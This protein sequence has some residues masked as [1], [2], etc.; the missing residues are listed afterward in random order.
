ML[1]GVSIALVAGLLVYE[2]FDGW[3]GSVTAIA[4]F[5]IWFAI[6]QF[7]RRLRRAGIAAERWIK[8]VAE[9]PKCR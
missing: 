9:R 7:R 5:A 4:V 2:A 6:R 1:I 3:Q 8:L